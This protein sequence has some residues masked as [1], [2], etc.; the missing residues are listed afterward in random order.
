MAEVEAEMANVIPVSPSKLPVAAAAI[1]AA[2]ASLR[3]QIQYVD[4]ASD[5]PARD[6]KHG[7]DDISRL[8]QLCSATLARY[9]GGSPPDTE[10]FALRTMT[11]IFI[12]RR[13]ALQDAEVQALEKQDK[14]DKKGTKDKEDKKEK[15]AKEDKKDKKEKRDMVADDAGEPPEAEA[16]G[17]VTHR[18]I[19]MVDGEAMV[20]PKPRSQAQ[21]DGQSL[22]LKSLR[23]SQSLRPKVKPKPRSQAK[24]T[25]PEAEAEAKV[26]G[27][28]MVSVSK[29]SKRSGGVEVAECVA[30]LENCLQR[31]RSGE[32]PERAKGTSTVTFGSWLA[33]TS[34]AVA[35]SDG[36]PA[37][38]Q[39]ATDEPVP[40]ANDEPVPS[41]RAVALP[42]DAEFWTQLSDGC[43]R[44]SDIVHVVDVDALFED[45]AEQ[46][47]AFA[48]KELPHFDALEQ[49]DACA[50]EELPHVDALEHEDA[51]APEELPHVDVDVFSSFADFFGGASSGSPAASP[52]KSQPFLALDLCPGLFIY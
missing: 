28:A 22:R 2:S 47:D 11:K 51:C 23:R 42:S 50:T 13:N 5:D 7:S 6:L 48:T 43:G 37:P 17:K 3:D 34:L 40:S 27:E 10:E 9:R 25:S 26:D 8:F 32:P 38:S 19:A 24:V 30:G 12:R 39:R 18:R 14:E 45:P 41:P 29:K 20:K 4:Y 44:P 49:K 15:V 16:E 21:V 31:K 52:L 46:E 35:K 36:E 1:E 33:G